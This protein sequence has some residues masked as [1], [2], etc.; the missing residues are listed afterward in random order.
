MTSSVRVAAVLRIAVVALMIGAMVLGTDRQD[1]PAQSALLACYGVAAIGVAASSFRRAGPR[2]TRPNIR[3]AVALGDVIAIGTFEM[4]SAGGYLPLAVMGLLPLLVA[5]E[6][7]RRRAVA[8]LAVGGVAF[9]A[10]VVFDPVLEP[11]FG[12]AV[13]I[14]LCALFVMLSVSAFV[15]AELSHQVTAAR[16]VLLADTLS[17][18]DTERRA[19]SERLHEGPLQTVLAARQDISDVA[20]SSDDPGLRRAADGLRQAARELRAASVG[21]H[22]AVLDQVGL[23]EAVTSLLCTATARSGIDYGAETDYPRQDPIDAMVFGVVRSLVSD[24]EQHAGVTR[25]RVTLRADDGWCLLDVVDDGVAPAHQHDAH[26]TA[27]AAHQDRIESLGG[28]WETARTT[29][30]TRVTVRIPLAC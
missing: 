30:G 10:A 17:A 1:W 20:R 29:T 25:G 6:L 7:S 18:F 2:A 19:I 16:R 9:T 13:T 26:R 15:I 11:R 28:T 5:L 22:P 21:L 23:A 12:A 4:L 8:V 3:T 27:L 14:Y 24:T